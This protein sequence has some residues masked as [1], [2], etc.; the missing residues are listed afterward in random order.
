[1][2]GAGNTEELFNLTPEER[3]L[4]FRNIQHDMR[5]S[6]IELAYSHAFTPDIGADRPS[7]PMVAGKKGTMQHYYLYGEIVP[8]DTG[9]GIKKP[10][11]TIEQQLPPGAAYDPKTKQVF[12]PTEP[13]DTLETRGTIAPI[14]VDPNTGRAV[15]A[16]PQIAKNILD[17]PHIIARA[18]ERYD[19]GLIVPN[20]QMAAEAQQIAGAFTS[21][22]VPGAAGRAVARG[23]G[24]SLG[25]GGGSRPVTPR[26]QLRDISADPTGLYSHAERATGLLPPRT[27]AEDVIGNMLKG[28]VKET[29]IQAMD[30]DKFL[31]GEGVAN[32]RRALLD[33]YNRIQKFQNDISIQQRYLREAPQGDI[34]HIQNQINW[35][36]GQLELA[37]QN[38]INNNKYYNTIRGLHKDEAGNTVRLVQPRMVTRKE[39]E[40]YIDEHRLRTSEVVYER[41]RYSPETEVAFDKLSSKEGQAEF[42]RALVAEGGPAGAASDSITSK[43]AINMEDNL[44]SLQGLNTF[45]SSFQGPSMVRLDAPVRAALTKVTGIPVETLIR[46][47]EVNAAAPRTRYTNYTF[48]PGNRTHREIV[49]RLHTNEAEEARNILRGMNPAHASVIGTYWNIPAESV[50]AVGRRL[51]REIRGEHANEIQRLRELEKTGRVFIGG[52]FPRDPNTYGFLMTSIERNADGRPTLMANQIQSDWTNLFNKGLTSAHHVMM[53]ALNHWV[54][55]LMRRL[56][57]EAIDSGAESITIP[58]A[59]AISVYNPGIKGSIAKLYDTVF[60]QRLSVIL[61]EFDRGSPRPQPI[62]TINAKTKMSLDIGHGSQPIQQ[63]LEFKITPAARA[64]AQSGEGMRILSRGVPVPS[65]N[66]EGNNGE[67]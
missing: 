44:G 35:L 67:D 12:A 10:D 47:S 18:K 28:G 34:P 45:V 63:G 17:I 55:P 1:M 51:V 23:A 40:D 53:S 7:N 57:K 16:L 41:P 5:P 4:Y 13:A 36:Q 38:Y 27:T 30:L 37:T 46:S 58:N 32:A 49:Q 29:E 15:V 56:V 64:R 11:G 61:R 42:R 54:D 8:T 66:R 31:L 24:P 43:L 20:E 21:G 60:P 26:P 22:G 33:N 3:A 62:H 25:A 9:M 19:N 52:H 6:D 48:N 14:A 39:V 2:A 65:G 50:P 59:A